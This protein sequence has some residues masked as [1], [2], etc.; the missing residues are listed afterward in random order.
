LF[1]RDHLPGIDP[2][3]ADPRPWLNAI[4]LGKLCPEL[5]VVRP[6]AVPIANAEQAPNAEAKRK[7]GG[8][9]QYGCLASR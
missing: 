8:E 6:K 5:K 4:N 9:A 3:E 2:L 7:Y 1:D